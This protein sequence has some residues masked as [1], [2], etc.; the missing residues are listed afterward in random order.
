M[1]KALHS[2]VLV[3]ARF[4]IL[5]GC[6]IAAVLS[7]DAVMR[8]LA[9]SGCTP[10]DTP[11]TTSSSQR[12]AWA[13]NALVSVNI[14]SNS[15]TQSQFENCI[16]PV[17]DNF[18]FINGSSTGNSSGVFFSVTFGPNAVASVNTSGDATNSSG[19]SNGLQ[20]NSANMGP[21]QMGYT[22]NGR[23][24]TNR[25]SA[26]ITISSHITDCTALQMD[27]AHELGHT[28]GLG[29]CNGP[30]SDCN[31]PGASIMNRG[32]CAS[33]DANGICTQTD[34]NNNTYGRTAP[35]PL[36]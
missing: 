8:V 21:V 32:V 30:T 25:N 36:R 22:A 2:P 23:N 17:F 27:L 24:A 9:Q 28:F 18:N 15:F 14:D 4:A 34:F 12:D 3:P 33:F 13:Q 26:V 10:G 11:S 20:V 29:H 16:K 19:I 7:V 31:T 5:A 6:L 1:T 35:S